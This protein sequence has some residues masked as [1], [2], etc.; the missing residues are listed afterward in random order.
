[1]DIDCEFQRDVCRLF[2][3]LGCRSAHVSTYGRKPAQEM[4]HVDESLGDKVSDFAFTPPFAIDTQQSCSQLL[5]AASPTTT[6]GR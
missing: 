4:R 2:S 1:M 5:A 3:F 6:A